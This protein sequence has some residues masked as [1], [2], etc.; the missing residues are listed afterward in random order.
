M[1]FVNRDFEISGDYINKK[2]SMKGRVMGVSLGP[3]RSGIDYTEG[4]EGIE[5]G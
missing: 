2:I 4:V 3:R 1:T 5:Y